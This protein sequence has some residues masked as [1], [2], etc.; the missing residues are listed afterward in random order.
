MARWQ[1]VAA[2]LAVLTGSIHSSKHKKARALRFTHKHPGAH[3]RIIGQLR[4]AQQEHEARRDDQFAARALKR[5][6]SAPDKPRKADPL[7]WTR[8]GKRLAKRVTP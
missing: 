7:S 6:R 3:R 5:A 4:L 1:N 8:R 2:L